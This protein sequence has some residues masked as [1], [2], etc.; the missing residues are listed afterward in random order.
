MAFG[1]S[2]VVGLGSIAAWLLRRWLGFHL[3]ELL[4]D[5]QPLGFA[6]LHRLD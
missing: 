1:A 3:S 6:D 5:G 2:G 4:P